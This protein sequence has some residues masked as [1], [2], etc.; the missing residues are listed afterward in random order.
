MNFKHQSQMT[1]TIL[2]EILNF[3]HWNKKTVD[4]VKWVR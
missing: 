1:E 4:K 3:I 2:F